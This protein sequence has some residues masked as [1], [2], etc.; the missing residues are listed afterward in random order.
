MILTLFRNELM[1]FAEKWDYENPDDYFGGIVCLHIELIRASAG[2]RQDSV[3]VL[4]PGKF[5]Q[6]QG[7][8]DRG[9]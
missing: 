2:R 3:N 1:T 6:L 8:R 9:G 5:L 4:E 7:R